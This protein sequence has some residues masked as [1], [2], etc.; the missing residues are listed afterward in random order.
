MTAQTNHLLTVSNLSMRYNKHVQAL[1]G[2]SFQIGT[3]ECLGVV[4]QSGSGKSTLARLLLRLDQ[5]D[6]GEM[7]LL[8]QPLHKLK[9]EALRQ[10]RR[11]VQIVF[12]DPAAALNPRL[13]IYQSVMEPLNNYPQVTPVFLR[14]IRHSPREM[15][16]RLLSMVGLPPEW[17]NRKP[18]QLSGGQKQ[19]VAIA[20]GI[21]LQP[22]LLICDEPTASL[23]VSVQAQ[24]LNLLK[25]LQEQLGMSYLFISHDIAAVRFMSNRILVMKEGQLVEQFDADQ[26][27]AAERH[28]YTQ[29]LVQA[30]TA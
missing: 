19:R 5:P 30:V 14:D 26:L 4:G 28:P 10:W 7:M 22:D 12:Q 15:A 11:H 8:G 6:E 23:D 3:G 13:S 16:E 25:D 9:G 24:I 18:H 29:Q 27:L 17:L 20:R 1:S 2:V 21:S